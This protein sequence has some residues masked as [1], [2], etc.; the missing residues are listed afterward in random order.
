M[1]SCA[2]C[3]S[4]ITSAVARLRDD[5]DLVQLRA[6]SPERPVDLVG[7]GLEPRNRRICRRN[8]DIEGSLRSFRQPGS[9]A[10]I[11]AR[12]GGR[13]GERRQS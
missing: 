2:A 9:A 4:T 8:A 3:W 6:R 10:A 5:V 1:R 12:P 13:A 11:N 7:S